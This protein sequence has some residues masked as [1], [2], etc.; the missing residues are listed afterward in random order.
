MVNFVD[1]NTI[2]FNGIP[3]NGYFSNNNIVVLRE[4][5]THKSIAPD[6]VDYFLKSKFS[7][8]EY[9]ASYLGLIAMVNAEK[10][11][12]NG[13]LEY[14]A[15]IDDKGVEHSK[16]E[17]KSLADATANAIYYKILGVLESK[18]AAVS[19]KLTFLGK[20]LLN[21]VFTSPSDLIHKIR[22]M[23]FELVIQ[24]WPYDEIYPT[25]SETYNPI[26]L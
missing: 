6:L 19:D 9:K 22:D 7:T 14:K 24:T 17:M 18:I 15:Y 2:T 5:D 3:T 16:D 4:E 12:T 10:D 21:I 13:T 23:K 8:T 20:S 11:M 25:K 26:V 1:E